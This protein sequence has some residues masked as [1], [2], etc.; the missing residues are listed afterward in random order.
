MPKMVSHPLLPNDCTPEEY[1]FL[2][3]SVADLYAKLSDPMDKFL[4]AFV[5]E[6]NYTQD[7][8]AESVNRSPGWVSQRMTKIKKILAV[9]YKI[10]TG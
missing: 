10:K 3:K 1:Y 8:A 4:L 6:L 5:Y 2:K 7:M 9:K